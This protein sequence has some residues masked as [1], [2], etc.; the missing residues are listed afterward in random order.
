MARAQQKPQ[1]GSNTSGHF[2]IKQ[3]TPVEHY[4]RSDFSRDLKKASR[5]RAK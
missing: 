1:T 2:K 3:T 4:K 5:R